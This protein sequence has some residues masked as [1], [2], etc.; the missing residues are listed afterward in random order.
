MVAL[1]IIVK[2]SNRASFSIPHAHSFGNGPEGVEKLGIDNE[3][4]RR[5]LLK[6]GRPQ[7]THLDTPMI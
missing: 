3:E 1:D 2:S 4:H 6:G 5:E 7:L